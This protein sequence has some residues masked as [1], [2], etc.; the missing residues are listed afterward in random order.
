RRLPILVTRF[1]AGL[2]YGI[3]LILSLCYVPGPLNPWL[4]WGYVG[5]LCLMAFSVDMGNPAVWAYAQDVGGKYTGSVLG[6]AN[7]WGN[8][9]AA[10]APLIYNAVLGETPVVAQWNLMFGV[11][12]LAF[13]L[14]ALC[15]LVMDSTKPLISSSVP[16]AG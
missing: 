3:C 12:I 5:A 14:S 7:M 16:G 9:G 13:A 11:C 15:S 4:P 8:L 2:G 6:W 1:S 10:V